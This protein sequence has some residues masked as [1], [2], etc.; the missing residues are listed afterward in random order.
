MAFPRVLEPAAEWRQHQVADPA[1]YTEHLGADDLRELEAALRAAKTA[2][3]DLLDIGA[4]QF[5]LPTLGPR[6]QR[7]ERELMDGRGF[8]VIRGLPRER[9]DDDD[10][11]LLYWG[12]GAHLGTPW[13]QNHHGHVLG[14]VI[15]QGKRPD[16][17]TARG[18]ELGAVGLPYHSDGSDLVGLMCLQTSA[19]GGESTVCNAVAIHNDLVRKEP[20]LAAALYQPLPYDFRGEQGPG[21]KPYYL[22]PVFTECA[23]RLFVR[24]IRPYIRASQRHPEAPRIGVLAERAMQR[25][26]ELTADPQ[27][28]VFMEFE[29]GDIQ[30]INNYHV[31]HG[32]R[33]YRDDPA[34]GRVRHLK[35]LWLETASPLDRPAHFQN[36]AR[37]HWERG[38]SVSRLQRPA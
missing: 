1:L 7:I 16:D 8:V 34:T 35:R 32:R 27:Y 5:P 36:R 25:L 21:G 23:D 31:L 9:Y 38:R 4:P 13:A 29:P 17:P 3:G 24:Y 15:D 10:L 6:L 12:I 20:E 11:S 18:N 19:E 14:D 22:V 37:S 2:S 26:D 33:P 28:E 30:F